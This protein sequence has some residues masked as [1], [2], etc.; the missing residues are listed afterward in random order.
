MNR[1]DELF[2]EIIETYQRHAQAARNAK[3]QETREMAEI[4]LNMDITAMW[5]LTQHIPDTRSRLV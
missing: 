2:F 3:Y 5:F 4:L 1:T